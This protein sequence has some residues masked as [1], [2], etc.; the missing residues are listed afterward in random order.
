[1]CQGGNHPPG[2]IQFLFSHVSP[3]RENGSRSCTIT[4][5]GA[6]N[7]LTQ[8]PPDV[9][10]DSYEKHKRILGTAPLVAAHDATRRAVARS[11][12]QGEAGSPR[13]TELLSQVG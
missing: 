4:P 9:A 12:D 7:L 3:G 2:L 13:D 1:M 5:E 6:L 11:H 8:L 10:G